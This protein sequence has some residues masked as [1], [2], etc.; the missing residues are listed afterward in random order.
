MDAL[1][2]KLS[3]ISLVDAFPSPGALPVSASK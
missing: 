3:V 2:K 1:R